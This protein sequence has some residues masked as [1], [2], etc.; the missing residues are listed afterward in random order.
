M[1]NI[2]GLD[3]EFVGE[4]SWRKFTWFS[5]ARWNPH[6]QSFIF[7]LFKECWTYEAETLLSLGWYP[8]NNLYQIPFSCYENFLMIWTIF[9]GVIFSATHT[10]WICSAILF[11]N[12]KFWFLCNLKSCEYF[13][14]KFQHRVCKMLN[15]KTVHAKEQMHAVNI[16][17][18]IAECLGVPFFCATRYS[19]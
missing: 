1:L 17:R 10:I 7:L 14:L 11:L 2:L 18:F 4:R 15:L 12:L 6:W 8:S 19:V 3:D 9:R 16:F 13:R 5:C